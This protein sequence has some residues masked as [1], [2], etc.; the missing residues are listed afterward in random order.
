MFRKLTAILV[1][2]AAS[3]TATAAHADWRDGHTRYAPP[4][5][6]VAPHHYPPVRGVYRWAPAPQAYWRPGHV[7]RGYAYHP[8]YRKHWVR[9]GWHDDH[10]HDRHN[11][12]DGRHDDHRGWNNNH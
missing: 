12:R 11:D 4:V 6:H 3:A 10:R 9:R 1:I 7:Y 8:A 2:G 5:H